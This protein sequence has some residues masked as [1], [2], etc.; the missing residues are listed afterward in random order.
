MSQRAAAR[1]LLRLLRS[2]GAQQAA[3]HLF[4]RAPSEPAPH[5]RRAEPV[6]HPTLEPYVF[7][8]GSS[9]SVCALLALSV[10]SGRI[11]DSRRAQLTSTLLRV[12]VVFVVV[13]ASV[14]TAPIVRRRSSFDFG[15]AAAATAAAAGSAFGALR[16]TDGERTGRKGTERIGRDQLRQPDD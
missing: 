5:E 16:S 15:C 12:V 13:A 6:A 11:A 1:G 4:A 9:E 14:R 8:R 10:V 3:L 7:A 2:L